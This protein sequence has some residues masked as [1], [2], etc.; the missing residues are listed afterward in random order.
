[1]PPSFAEGSPE[2]WHALYEVN[3]LHILQVTHAPLPSMLD[4]ASGTIINVSSI[5]GMRG[6]PPDSVYGAFKAAA[7]HFTRSFGTELGSKAIKVSG[8]TPDLTQTKQSAFQRFDP[9]ELR[10]K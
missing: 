2:H 7:I 9:H 6:Y 10:D 1:M 5:E 3:L 4:R 8:I